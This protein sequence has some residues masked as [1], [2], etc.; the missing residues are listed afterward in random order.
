MWLSFQAQAVRDPRTWIA[1]TRD[2][3]APLWHGPG[4]VGTVFFSQQPAAWKGA[5][6]G[7][8]WKQVGLVD[9]G[10]SRSLGLRCRV[11]TCPLWTV[12]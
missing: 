7:G 10:S 6:W 5:R 9:P 4:D 1:E 12:T 11:G 3:W 2:V 8:S